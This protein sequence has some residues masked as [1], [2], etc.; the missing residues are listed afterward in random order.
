[1]EGYCLAVVLFRDLPFRLLVE[2]HTSCV[3]YI[4]QLFTHKLK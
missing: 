1:M 3:Y 4:V 2:G